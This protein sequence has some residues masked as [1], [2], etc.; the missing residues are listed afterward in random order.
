[1]SKKQVIIIGA[2]PC[3]LGAAYRFEELLQQYKLDNIDYTVVDS[4]AD[5]GGLARTVRDDN[6][7]L[8]D[9]GGHVIFSHYKY[10]TDLLSELVPNDQWNI[11]QREAWVYMRNNYIP[12]PLQQ[13]IHRLPANEIIQCIDGLI[14]NESNKHKYCKP[15]NFDEWLQQSFGAGLCDIFMRPYNC[16]VWAYTTDK[17]NVE[18]MGERVA[19][20]NTTRIIENI[21][22]QRDELGWG[23]NN[24]F[25]FPKHGGTG[26]IWTA[27]YNTLPKHKFQFNKHVMHIDSLNKL[28][29]YTDHTTMKYDEL[30]STMPLDKLIT[31]AHNLSIPRNQLHDASKLFKYSSS[32]IIGFGLSGQPSNE[33][34]TKCWLYYPESNCPYYRVTIF[35]NY[36]SSHVPSPNT[37]WSIMC[38]V[39]ESCDKPVNVDTIVQE[40]EQGLRNTKLIDDSIEILSR[41][42]TRL[43]YGYPTP[44]VGRDEL[45]TPLFAE[46]ESHHIYSRGR[47]GA[48]KYEVSNQDHSLMQGVECVDRILFGTDEP[49]FKTPNIVNSK[50]DKLIN[51]RTP[52]IFFKRPQS[53][54]NNNNKPQLIDILAARAEKHLYVEEHKSPMPCHL[55]GK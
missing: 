28:I 12:Y 46:L 50:T 7:F 54:L 49:T 37:Q 6:G 36:S 20:I 2:G 38:E 5:E 47:F 44:F 4:A 23:P 15:C 41:Y 45:C 30:I 21:I 48:W 42:H 25:R 34:R 16:K 29:T 18:W 35:S 33:L 32:H 24:I 55:N 31:C 39:S 52:Y 1:M 3:G 8:W 14:Q 27:L 11:L 9:M 17:M 51:S 10:F 40:A 19:T 13:N 26:S 43:E 53:I 22:L